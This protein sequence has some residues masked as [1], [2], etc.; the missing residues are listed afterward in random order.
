MLCP[1]LVVF[2]P[3]SSTLP[4]LLS[5][6]HRSLCHRRPLA[7]RVTFPFCSSLLQPL[8]HNCSA[9]SVPMRPVG[10]LA[11]HRPNPPLRLSQPSLPPSPGQPHQASC[12][13]HKS[14]VADGHPGDGHG[15]SF[16]SCCRAELQSKIRSTACSSSVPSATRNLDILTLPRLQL[17]C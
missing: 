14:R 9:G 15:T 5:P 8:S 3:G 7:Q 12:H 4:L 16:R 6:T 1:A 2:H 10:N 17:V 13:P 11:W